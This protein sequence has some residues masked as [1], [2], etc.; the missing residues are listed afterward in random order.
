MINAPIFNDLTE[1]QKNKLLE[2][3]SIL[4]YLKT[5]IIFEE[6]NKSS[7]LYY[8]EQG[9]IKRFISG[10]ENRESI[11][12]V[13]GPGDIFGHRILFNDE[14]HFDS[15]AAITDVKLHFIPKAVF[16]QFIAEN[17]EMSNSYI[18]LLSEDSIRHIRHSQVVTQLSLKQR[19]AFYL[20]YLQSKNLDKN[21]MG[22][23]ISRTDLANLLGTVKESAVRI[24][25]EYKTAN[26]IKSMGRKLIILDYKYL[27]TVSK[28]FK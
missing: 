22:V 20:L 21:N 14:R 1:K 25:H 5:S 2:E 7:G 28:I 11:F 17:N 16:L 10:L 15:S 12:E 13:C 6:G 23:E 3:S 19:T 18:N 8:I 26:A 4:I 9:T 27:L 24:L